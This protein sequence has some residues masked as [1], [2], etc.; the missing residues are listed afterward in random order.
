LGR[1][2]NLTQAVTS[3]LSGDIPG[4][5]LGQLLFIVQ[6]TDGGRAGRP[7]AEVG[8][9]AATWNR[10]MSGARGLGGS[11]PSAASEQKIAAALR[12]AAANRWRQQMPTTVVVTAKIRWAGYYNPVPF[13]TT[14]LVDLRL[15]LVVDRF[16][17]VRD[18]GARMALLA[19]VRDRYGVPVSFEGKNVSVTFLP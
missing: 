18:V 5:L 10:W 3:G 13:R 8:V 15:D 19:A 12:R 2:M 16:G 11:R 6:N 4:S 1:A 9:T 7:A 14:R 17:A